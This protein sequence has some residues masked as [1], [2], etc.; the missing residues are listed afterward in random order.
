MTQTQGQ[1]V[2]TKLIVLSNA[3]FGPREVRQMVNAIA[4]DYTQYRALRDAVGELESRE[5]PSPAANVRL[6]VALYLLGRYRRAVEVLLKGDG[7][8]LAHFYL[9]KAYHAQEQ[10]E[11]AV[12]HFER[13][14]QG[15]YDGDEVSLA[16]AESLRYAGKPEEAMAVLDN[17]SGAVEQTAE[18]LYQR[19]STVAAIGGNPT[20]VVAL[21]ERAV[22]ADRSHAGA[23]FGLALENDRRGNDDIALELYKRSA[24]RFP[25]HVGSLLNLGLIYEDRD[26]F[27]RAVQ[28]Y[29]RVLDVFPA[30]PRHRCSSRTPRPRAT[31]I[32]TRMPRRNATA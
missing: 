18:Y 29:Q 20:E 31:C 13:A 21:Y 22:D 4:V 16:R 1:E 10:F 25:A 5:D 6:G 23:L 12:Q 11:A 14:K 3:S 9:G 17:L 15:G 26:Q 19:G 32:T 7:G 8:A 24:S 28:C 2:D 30:H 27:D